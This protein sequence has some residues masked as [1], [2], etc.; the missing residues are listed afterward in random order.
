MDM[1]ISD[2]ESED[3]QITKYEQEEEKER[4]LFS[5]PVVLD[6]QPIS[7]EDLEKCRLTRDVL[8]KFCMAPWFQDYV[9]R[10]TVAFSLLTKPNMPF[11]CLGQIS[12]WPGK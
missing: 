1:E 5:K 8:A 10:N 6:E 7:M 2:E 4:K 12:H 11:R 3:G 9:Q